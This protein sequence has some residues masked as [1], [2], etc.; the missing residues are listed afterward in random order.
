MKTWRMPAVSECGESVRPHRPRGSLLDIL[1]VLAAIGLT[2]ASAVM[3]ALPEGEDDAASRNT[4]GHDAAS[5]PYAERETVVSIYAGAPYYYR[6]D[7]HMTRPDGTDVTLKRLGWDGDP[8]YFPIDGGL[9]SV[10]WRGSSG[11]MIDFLHNKAIA[12]TGKGSHGRKIS[13]G[14]IDEVETVGTLKGNPSPGTLKLTDLFERLEFTHGHNVLLF[15]P[16][17]RLSA[18]SPR[19]RPYLGIGAGV[20]IPHVEVRFAGEGRETRTGEYQL[21]GPA[22]QLVAGIELRSGRGSYYLEYKFTW[23]KIAAA[24]TGDESGKNV[25]LPSWIGVLEGPVDLYR[26]AR[27]WWLGEEPRYGRLSTRL[28]SHQVFIGAGYAWPGR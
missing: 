3:S 11:F 6:S 12:R 16:V 15:G 24:L 13:N 26:Q 4:A 22:A 20:A 21:A 2:A 14:V 10:H 23:A 1:S 9:R 28:S 5:T 25:D 27:S 17:A 18:F 8:F 19:L 7:V